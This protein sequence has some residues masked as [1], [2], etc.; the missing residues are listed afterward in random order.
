MDVLAFAALTCMPIVQVADA[1]RKSQAGDEVRV[2]T[3]VEALI[4]DMRAFAHM[5]GNA[6]DRVQ[7]NVMVTVDLHKT[8]DHKYSAD[9]KASG[10][11]ESGWIIVLKVLPT[12]RLISRSE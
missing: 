7:E 6:V 8:R 5:S 10:R 1:V 2:F 11:T 9:R 12:N 4:A 3:D